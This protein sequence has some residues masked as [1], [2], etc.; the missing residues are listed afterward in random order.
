MRPFFNA[1]FKDNT[2]MYRS[3][4]TG[5]TRV[6]KESMFSDFNNIVV[7]S[8]ARS[9]YSKYFGFTQDEVDELLEEYDLID[10]KEDVKYWYDGFTIGNI[11]DIYNPW[12]ILNYLRM[13]RFEPYWI[14]TS[15][16]T[17]INDLVKESGKKV[18]MNFERLMNHQTIEVHLNE[19]ISFNE[20]NKNETPIYTLLVAGG[21]LKIVEGIKNKYILDITNYEVRTM[22]EEMIENWFKDDN[23]DEEY[24]EFIKAMLNHDVK[25][26]NKF[27]NNVMRETFSSFDTSQDSRYPEKFYH[28]FTLGLLLD[29]RKHNYISSN[30]ESGYGRYDI[31]IEP[32]DNNKPGYILE[33]KVVD[34]DDNETMEEVCDNALK[35]IEEKKYETELKAKGIKT[36]YKYALAFEGKRVLIKA[37]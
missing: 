2:S 15:G 1:T 5:I 30:K 9:E 37:G 36:I 16:N 6:S 23:V 33:F 13:K 14:N 7:D 26:M 10:T 32:L 21:Y 3:V 29:L 24:N 25:K 11:K 35:Q 12:S 18:K 22:F 17:L 27:M 20:L 8:I 31:M 19:Y 4:L 34:K 28:G